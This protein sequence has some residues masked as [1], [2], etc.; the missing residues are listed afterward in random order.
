MAE[1]QTGPDFK[2]ELKFSRALLNF[3]RIRWWKI[4]IKKKLYD[5]N[6]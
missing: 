4:E 5:M 3:H 6:T 1:V 2:F